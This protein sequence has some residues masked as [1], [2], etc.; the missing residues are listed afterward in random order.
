[1]HAFKAAALAAIINGLFTTSLIA[2]ES[3]RAYRLEDSIT[4]A[5]F[6]GL[7]GGGKA[8]LASPGGK[9]VAVHVTRADSQSNTNVAE[10]RIYEAGR[11]GY[12]LLAGSTR[13]IASRD[14]GE[15]I[16]F[17][18]WD[19][20]S[21]LMYLAEDNS[22]VRQVF[23]YDLA[24]GRKEQMTRHP[25]AITAFRRI[26][27]RLLFAADSSNGSAFNREEARKHG[28]V[29]DR[30][31]LAESLTGRRP[32]LGAASPQELFISDEA[33][34]IKVDVPAGWYVYPWWLQRLHASPD[35][36]YAVLELVSLSEEGA[37]RPSIW[38]GSDKGIKAGPVFTPFSLNMRSGQLR[39]FEADRPLITEVGEWKRSGVLRTYAQAPCRD[40][41]TSAW[42]DYHQCSQLIVE[43]DPAN[44]QTVKF[45]ITAEKR[46]FDWGL[47]PVKSR[48]GWQLA[49][50][51]GPRTRPALVQSFADRTDV[52]WDPNEYLD[53]V[54]IVLP[55]PIKWKDKDGNEY[56]GALYMPAG[57]E[58]GGR[59]PL[60]IQ[61]HSVDLGAFALDG[62]NSSSGFA[63][64][65]AAAMGAVVVQMDDKYMYLA[66]QAGELESSRGIEC[67]DALIEALASRGLVDTRRVS[68]QTF[69]RTGHLVRALF[70]SKYKFASAIVVDS[71]QLSPLQAL[72][73]PG[74]E[75]KRRFM[76]DQVGAMPIGEG[77]QRWLEITPTFNVHR[78][79]T[80]VL[81]FAF[82]DNQLLIKW[83]FYS[84]LRYRGTP[85]ELVYHPDADHNPVLPSQRK[86]I[87]QRVATWY[88]E[89]LGLSKEA[90]QLE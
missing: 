74:N 88:A 13:R 7:F 19:G 51:Q 78:I 8:L 84:A 33:R 61:T 17:L 40:E 60:V 83:E 64:Q 45:Q 9:R 72:L 25:Q 87:L 22:G 11:H 27:A 23:R 42:K 58:Q 57:A 80:P 54:R 39:F 14:G 28:L 52:L 75:L 89:R 4:F 43:L 24:S 29:V 70:D 16:Q 36:R 81:L 30:L 50:R 68:L 53:Q 49:I 34:T 90:L 1:M 66:G 37:K 38:N 47:K 6:G 59:H 69:S 5:N 86:A 77:L 48:S 18:V 46:W 76:M 20:E 65:A 2:A 12:E 82:G 71:L 55:E 73:S 62:L 10:L 32:V 63:A 31:S 26:G 85:S 15:P 41:K 35:G 56:S 79:D 21:A 67:V 44:P 3:Q